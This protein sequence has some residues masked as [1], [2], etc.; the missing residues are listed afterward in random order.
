MPPR[1]GFWKACVHCG[2]KTLFTSM[3]QRYCTPDC[4]MRAYDERDDH[5]AATLAVPRRSR[6]FLTCLNC[7]RHDHMLLTDSDVR[8]MSEVR[9]LVCRGR[10]TLDPDAGKAVTGGGEVSAAIKD[11]LVV[12]AESHI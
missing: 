11:R 9:C 3:A 4:Q 5:K 2:R 7:G 10:M 12:M 1:S 8:V 6:Y